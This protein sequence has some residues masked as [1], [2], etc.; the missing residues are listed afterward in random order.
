MTPLV[1]EWRFLGY[2]SLYGYRMEIAEVWVACDNERP[3]G[4]GY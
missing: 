2:R 3:L 1:V 4:R